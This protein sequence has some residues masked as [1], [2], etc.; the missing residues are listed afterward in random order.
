MRGWRRRRYQQTI[1]RLYFFKEHSL[2]WELYRLSHCRLHPRRF[3]TPNFTK[4]GRSRWIGLLHHLKTKK[5][6]SLKNASVVSAFL[7]HFCRLCREAI[8]QS[9]PSALI[10]WYQIDAAPLS[11]GMTQDDFLQWWVN[12]WTLRQQPHTMLIILIS[13]SFVSLKSSLQAAAWCF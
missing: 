1:L 7:N 13:F 11:R 12:I 3:Q 10:L 6:W 4:D 5:G 8:T 2:Q 9:L